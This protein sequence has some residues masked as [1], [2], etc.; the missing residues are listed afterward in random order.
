[1]NSTITKQ[2]LAFDRQHIWHPYSTTTNRSD[3]FPITGAQGCRLQLADGRELIDGMSSWWCT[4]HGYNH[5]LMNQAVKTQVEQFS[6]VMF[7][8]LTHKPAIDL[9]Q[10]LINMTPESLETVFFADSGSVAVEVAVKMAMQYWQARGS[11]QKN[12]MLTVRG[13]YYGDTTG[14]MSL[15]DPDNG[16]HHWFTGILPQHFFLPRPPCAFGSPCEEEHIRDLKHLLERHHAQ[17][18]AVIIEPVVQGAGGM[19]FYSPQYLQEVRAL[20]TTYQVLL[21]HDEI[22]TGFG[23]TGKLFAMEHAQTVPDIMCVG[24]ALTGGYMTMAA[25]LCNKNISQTISEQ[26]AFM[27]GPTFMAN[28]LACAAA[29]ASLSILQTGAWE[30]QVATIEYQ[31]QQGLQPCVKLAGVADVRVLGA[32]G[33]V[34][35]TKPVNMTNI[36]PEFVKRGLWVRPFG[37]LIYIMPPYIIDNEELAQL[38]AG[39]TDIIFSL[40]R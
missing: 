34:E 27:H 29:N 18:A 13:G 1:M 38:C 14:A 2:D 19:H 10:N 32:I 3:M 21:I 12:K 17:L 40:E 22:A 25:T 35:M 31:L 24:K 9:A 15:C 6:H 30:K 23:R 4:I 28:P 39:I 11:N 20:C 8:G 5:P 26:G 33:V 16:M 36:Q 7:G 37:K